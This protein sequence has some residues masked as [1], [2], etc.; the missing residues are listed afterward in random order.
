MVNVL[1]SMVGKGRRNEP[2]TYS[3]AEGG[4]TGAATV[5]SKVLLD[6]Y[7]VRPGGIE[8]LVCLGTSGS[9]FALWAFALG[10]ALPASYLD[11]LESRSNDHGGSG[12]VTGEL[13]APLRDAMR[14]CLEIAV[15]LDLIPYGDGSRTGDALGEQLGI[16]NVISGHVAPGDRVSLDVTHALR[17]LPMLAL[18]SALLLR[19]TGRVVVDGI[20][21]GALDLAQREEAVPVL[22]LD[23]LL[24]L[25][26]W[27]G[28]FAVFERSGDFGIFADHMLADVPKKA[29]EVLRRTAFLERTL[30]FDDARRASH[31]FRTFA[32]AR[33]PGLSGVFEGPVVD[34]L[35]PVQEQTTLA[36][37]RAIAQLH[38]DHT[39]Y[40]RAA[41]VGYEAVITRVQHE[42][43]FGTRDAAVAWLREEETKALGDG[44]P[45]SDAVRARFPRQSAWRDLR[46]IRNALA[47]L[48]TPLDPRL[49][50]ALGDELALID[51][52]TNAFAVLLDDRSPSLFAR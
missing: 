15:E 22:R 2:R 28:A 7:K 38:L 25:A 20:W 42:S 11:A 34:R 6:R 48:D 45:P 8:K 12:S 37:Q 9:N 24:G 21:Y 19:R 1:I 51:L 5:F 39:D 18:L 14:N 3:F 4:W 31:A 49:V 40:V 33:W 35:K 10:L 50:A 17:H 41:L 29:I 36:R 44:P 52:L 46:K 16:V 32:G 27:L 26:D 13:L 47:H 43:K 30:R 23:G